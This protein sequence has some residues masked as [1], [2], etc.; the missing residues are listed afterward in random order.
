MKIISVNCGSSS[1]KFQLFDMPSEKVL[2]FGLA[3]RI[4]L[5]VGFFS[6]SVNG[7]KIN[8]EL[9]IKDHVA[10]VNLLLE[11]LVE[12]KIVE[13]LDEISAAGHR[14]V[15]GGNV[16]SHSVLV[17]DESTRIVDEFSDL[18]PLH[19]TANLIGYRSF[20]AAL[21]NIKHTYVF[22]TAF[23][24][25][26]TRES[27][28]YPVPYNWLEDYNVRRYGAHG[29][30]HLY[31][32][33][34]CIDLMNLKDKPSK[35][36]TCHLGN[37]ASITAIKDGKSINTTMGFTP[38]GGIMMGTRSGDL[39]PAIVSYMANKLNKRAHEIIEMLNKESGML[40]V[41]GI[42]SDARDIEEAVNNG[43]QRAL[44]TQEI[45]VNRVINVIGGY[46][47]QLG[48]LD[49]I[50][51]TAGLGEND[52]VLRYKIISALSEALK[53]EVNETN[54][55]KRG[56]ELRITTDSSKVAVW[57]IPTNEELVI[58]RDTYNLVK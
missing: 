6:I 17:D 25:T 14:V 3:E 52:A 20:A 42:S 8:K 36:I 40:G 24:Q 53:I 5:E 11:A 22:D 35:I 4:G 43:N 13:S 9:Q 10:A 37:G 57:V 29:T 45:Y 30:S 46:I 51:F 48:G 44:L 28:V 54:N 38:L 39:D 49:A 15:Q 55:S 1:L 12:H 56:Q 41:S 2:T 33:Q 32:S 16:F 58:A 26:M 21:P 19:N 7:E 31:V 27:Y 23:H 50:V 18:A 34:R 47:M